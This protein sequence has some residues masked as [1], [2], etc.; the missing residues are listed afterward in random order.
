M[1]AEKIRALGERCRPRDL[2]DVVNLHRREDFPAAPEDVREVLIDKCRTKGVPIPSVEAIESSEARPELE[3]EWENMLGHQVQRLPP[4]ASF[5]DELPALFRW[6]EGIP[7]PVPLARASAQVSEDPTWSPPPT[8]QPWGFRIPVESIRFAGVN[9]LC[10]E[11]GYQGTGRTI[12]PYS[13]R[14]TRDGNTVLYAIRTD[15]R[16]LRC[17]RVDRIESVTVT[18]IP[19]VP[20][21]EVEFSSRGLLSVPPMKGSGSS[22]PSQRSLGRTRT[23]LPG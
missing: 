10:V 5:L 16:E 7:R 18:Q 2:Y 1:F 3:S 14:R 22:R 4:L 20:V 8:A 11:L 12:E 17:Y 9:R 21:Y 15:N 6:L 19:F 13:L 23:K